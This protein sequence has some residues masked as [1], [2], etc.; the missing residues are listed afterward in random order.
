MVVG[1][2]SPAPSSTTSKSDTVLTAT[3]FSGDAAPDSV[4][5]ILRLENFRGDS[6]GFS[7]ELA[8][9]SCSMSGD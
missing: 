9:V 2:V 1:L 5:I 3:G 4:E 6:I 8:D 7:G